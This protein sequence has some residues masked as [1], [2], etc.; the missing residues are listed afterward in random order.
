VHAD[1]RGDDAVG[2]GLC[3]TCVGEPELAGQAA[4]WSSNRRRLNPSGAATTGA[5][6]EHRL[7]VPGAWAGSVTLCARD[8]AVGPSGARVSGWAGHGWALRAR[9]CYASERRGG[10]GLRFL[11]V[12][13]APDYAFPHSGQD[14]SRRLELLEQR[15]DP[16]TKRRIGS[17]GVSEGT[18][19]LE[20][21]GGRGSIT[22]WLS[23]VVGPQDA[24]AR[25]ICR[26]GS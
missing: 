18:R 23:G 22:R 9:A 24:S 3:L 8:P 7:L 25:P 4:S 14:E 1:R 15:L 26:W 13:E 20:I 2:G 19:C 10:R 21:G 5:S 6:A 16:V 12:G 11:A 17:L